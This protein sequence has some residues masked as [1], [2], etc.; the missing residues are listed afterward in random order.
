MEVLKIP[1]NKFLDVQQAGTNNDYIFKL[2]HKKEYQNHLGT[3]HASALFALAESSSGEF[4]FNQLR[5]YNLDVIPVVR[6][7]E[8]KYSK[9]A[10]GTVFSKASIIDSDIKEILSELNKTKRTIVKVR[11]DIYNEESEKLLTSRF[12]WFIIMN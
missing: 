12:D 8:M 6:K 4:L 10:R 2:E 11:V 7:V 9:P 1:F 3:I 5:D